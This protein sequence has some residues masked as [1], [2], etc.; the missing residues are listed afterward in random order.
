MAIHS[1]LK[2]E[3]GDP[4][5]QFTPEQHFGKEFQMIDASLIELKED[6]KESMILRQNPTDKKLLAKH[7]KVHVK[8]KSELNLIIINEADAKLQQIFLYD[9]YLHKNSTINFGIFA[10]D[11]KLNKHIVQVHFEDDS[12]FNAYGLLTNNVG[13]DTEIIT[14]IIHKNYNTISNQ[15]FLGMAG[16]NSQTV[17]QGMV[18]LEEGS[19]GSDANITSSN[20][21]TGLKGRCFSKPE[22]YIDCDNTASSYNSVTD[23][24]DKEKI[25]YL[26]T[27][28][29]SEK[30][31]ISLVTDSF[32]NLVLNLIQNDELKQEI[33]QIYA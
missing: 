32:K 22:I 21:T 28:G 16:E 26:Q 27:R 29:F 13:G 17:F 9:V 4:D 14:K 7:L 33:A 12:C 11:G 10:K 6:V 2:A 3:P 23:R 24:L 20:M 25:Y 15:L 31:A 18:A 30:E 19:D 8:E 5:W 1:F